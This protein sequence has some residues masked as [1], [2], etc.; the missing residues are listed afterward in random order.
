[1]S[2]KKLTYN[3]I[4]KEIYLFFKQPVYEQ[5]ALK[6]EIS[7][8]LSGLKPFSLKNNKYRLRKSGAFSL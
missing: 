4:C 3:V 7:K 1:M 6:K 8:Q 2:L 5:L